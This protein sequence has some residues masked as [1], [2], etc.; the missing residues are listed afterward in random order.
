MRNFSNFPPAQGAGYFK[1]KMATLQNLLS[2]Q[3]IKNIKASITHQN[4]IQTSVPHVCDK[5]WDMIYDLAVNLGQKLNKNFWRELDCNIDLSGY[6]V[7]CMKGSQERQTMT[8]RFNRVWARHLGEMLKQGYKIIWIEKTSA[9]EIT[10]KNW[11][12]TFAQITSCP[13]DK[14]YDYEMTISEKRKIC[15]DMRRQRQFHAATRITGRKALPTMQECWFQRVRTKEIKR[16]DKAIIR[17]ENYNS[18]VRKHLRKIA[19]A[20]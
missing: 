15:S 3:Q 4:E 8:V 12:Q 16:E 20:L 7:V 9:K 17:Q 6:A 14:E 18:G 1:K 10:W 5:A 19:A 11:K 2:I 13:D